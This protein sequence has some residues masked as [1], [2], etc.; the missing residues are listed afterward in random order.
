[1]GAVFTMVYNKVIEGLTVR[2]RSA[3]IADAEIT[4]KMRSDPEKTKYVHRSMGTVE[5]QCEYLKK[6]RELL[7]DYLFI[8]EDL[9]GHPIGMK[10]VYNYDIKENTVET[11]RFIGYGSQVQNIEALKLGFDFAFEELGVCKIKMAALENNTVMLGIQKKFGVRFTHRELVADMN[12][13][14]L[15]SELTKDAYSVS[16]TR[17]EALIKRFAVR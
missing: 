10:G 17:I 1:M 6:Q 7:G 13:Y 8:I 14:N 16:R 4:F 12:Q 11:G 5:D 9:N 2:L 15:C 3:E